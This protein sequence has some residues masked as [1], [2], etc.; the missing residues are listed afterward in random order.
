MRRD[1]FIL[2]LRRS[3]N[4]LPQIEVEDIIRD[5]NEYISDAMIAGRREEDVIASLGD[6]KN[7][8]NS[9]QADIKIQKAESAPTF[10]KQVSSTFS[11]L[12]AILALAPLNIIFVLGPFLILLGFLIAGWAISMGLF[13]SAIAIFAGFFMKLI[14]MSVGFWTQLSTL[15]FSLGM[16]GSSIIGFIIMV[17]ITNAVLS[18]TISYL[19]WNLNFI[20]AKA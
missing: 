5:Q 6:P 4:K 1:Q 16:I 8:A 10:N 3:L 14:F 11:A 12:L 13:A 17:W 15:F 18:A 19:K 9:L 20:K 2:E 7:L